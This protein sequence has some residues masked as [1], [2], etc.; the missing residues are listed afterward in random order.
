MST[1]NAGAVTGYRSDHRARGELGE[2]GMRI[3][4]RGA[5]HYPRP[6]LIVVVVVVVVVAAVDRCKR[7]RPACDSRAP[8]RRPRPGTYLTRSGQTDDC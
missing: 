3:T 8:R 1:V 2:L 5:S 7:R 6:G 4:G